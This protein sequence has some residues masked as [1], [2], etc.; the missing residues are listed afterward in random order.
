MAEITYRTGRTMAVVAFEELRELH[1]IV[2][3]GPNWNEIDQIVVTL[4]L[5]SVKQ[6]RTTV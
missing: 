4:N 3:R 6:Q 5:S 2:E 1:D